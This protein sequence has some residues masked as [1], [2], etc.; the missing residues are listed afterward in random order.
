MANIVIC[1]DGTWN[2][3]EQDLEKD[4][5]TNALKLARA[6]SPK[7]GDL[8]QHGFYDW[9]VGSYYNNVVG[10]LTDGVDTRL[11]R[12]RNHVYR[13]KKPL[14]RKLVVE[15]KPTSVHPSVKLR[16]EA[17]TDYRPP[18]LEKLM[19]TVGWDTLLS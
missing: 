10:G 16:Y 14:H 12:S 7:N 13:L 1:A 15:G 3:P 8:T 5:A 17:D 6:I 2:R 11:H 4:H 19:E 9:G 18:N